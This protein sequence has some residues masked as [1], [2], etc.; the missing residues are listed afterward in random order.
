MGEKHHSED[1]STFVT[2]GDVLREEEEE[3][4]SD[5]NMRRLSNCPMSGRATLVCIG[6]GSAG[7]KCGRNRK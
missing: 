5:D 6:H 7:D 2:H 1:N 3:A 4:F